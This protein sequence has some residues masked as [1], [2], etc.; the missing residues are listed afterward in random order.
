MQIDEF[1]KKITDLLGYTDDIMD[2]VAEE[3]TIYPAADGCL[4]AVWRGEAIPCEGNS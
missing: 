2:W 3:L 4:S 1:Q